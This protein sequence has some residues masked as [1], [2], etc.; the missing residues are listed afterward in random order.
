MKILV[1][2]DEKKICRILCLLL[3]DEGFETQSC[4]SGEDALVEATRFNPDVVLLDLVLPG[5]N[6][7]ETMIEM[8]KLLYG[9]QYIIITANGDV[10]KAVSAIQTGAYNFIK[11]PFDND[12]L[13]GLVR[14]AEEVKK[15]HDK[16]SEL[17][18]RLDKSDYCSHIIG[19]TP[20][21]AEVKRLI[22]VVAPS[23]ASVL[24]VGESGTGKEL[25]VKAIHVLSKRRNK[26]LLAVNCSAISENLFESEF[27]GHV[28]GAF[29]GAIRD[30]KGKF[31][32]AKGGTLFL[33]ELSDMPLAF[34]AK[35]LRVLESEE[36][37]PVGSSRSV[38]TDVRIIAATNRNPQDLIN[39]GLF[40]LDL[41]YRLKTFIL[42]IPP[43]RE[44]VEDISLLTGCFANKLNRKVSRMALDALKHHNW[45]GNI[46][47]LK[48]EIERASILSNDLIK[49][50]HFS[51]SGKNDS[52]VL[53]DVQDDDFD[54]ENILDEI[55]R[56]YF[57]NAM[58]VAGG[59]KVKAAKLLNLSYRKFDY[60]WKKYTGDK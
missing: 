42:E 19:D 8:K 31:Q 36:V 39:Q 18:H 43:L 15:M 33:D 5:M 58:Q 22:R 10:S 50:E 46:R 13:I 37:T 30:N 49:P 60:Q 52:G 11:K 17:V 48:N 44:R 54:L 34:Q 47:E 56:K 55:R 6:G 20:Q 26:P 40:R 29:T 28:K 38:K 21:I 23:E 57:V 45:P 14:G 25:V 2:D 35:L 27:F 3:E 1:V 16:V 12:E 4:N 53:A 9:T 7:I 32:E 51:F 24:V 41:Y 59:N